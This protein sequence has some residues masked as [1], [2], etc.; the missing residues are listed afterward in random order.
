M[1]FLRPPQR[2]TPDVPGLPFTTPI[3]DPLARAPFLA[4][5]VRDRFDGFTWDGSAWRKT[6][7]DLLQARLSFPFAVYSPLH[8]E[9]IV[10]GL[11]REGDGWQLCWSVRTSDARGILHRA[12]VP[13]DAPSRFPAAA[14]GGASALIHVVGCTRSVTLAVLQDELATLA[15]SPQMGPWHVAY[16]EER[17]RFVGCDSENTF[18]FKETAWCLLCSGSFGYGLAWDASSRR[19]LRREVGGLAS[20]EGTTWKPR[21]VSVAGVHL[22]AE[23]VAD[24]DRRALLFIGGQ[25]FDER[26]GDPSADTFVSERGASFQAA[27]SAT[28]PLVMGRYATSGILQGRLAIVNHSSRTVLVRRRGLEFERY[29]LRKKIPYDEAFDDRYSNYALFDDQVW[30]LGS[31]GAIYRAK[32]GDLLVRVTRPDP[33][34]VRYAH[35]ALL[36]W[37]APGDR[38]VLYDAEQSRKTLVLRRGSKTL[39]SIATKTRPPR[40]SAGIVSTEDGIA[41]VTGGEFSTK[42]GAWQGGGR[43]YHWA[44]DRWVLAAENEAAS[45]RTILT[46]PGEKG[47]FLVFGPRGSFRARPGVFELRGELPPDL[48]LDFPATN[49]STVAALDPVARS[50]LFVKRDVVFEMPVT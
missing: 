42:A 46:D 10:G 14:H 47:A 25:D 33:K 38:L 17:Q 20:W 30:A 12:Y 24:P 16:D 40:G 26:G 29:P 2:L 23:L 32:L 5:E 8:R 9:V 13:I 11:E 45:S 35:R 21:S 50:V 27:P 6:H 18:E 36:A 19:L 48:D 31:D 4:S 1:A 22:G 44:D 3:W 28:A 49:Q 37:D 39:E 7:P 34:L 41:L 43:L 15:V